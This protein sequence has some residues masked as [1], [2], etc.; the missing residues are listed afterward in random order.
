MNRYLHEIEHAASETLRLIWFEH[1]QMEEL[2]ARIASA[3]AEV[4]DAAQRLAWLRLNPDMDDDNLSTAV[5]W[6]T[7]FGPEKERFYA[8]KSRPD[9]ESLIALRA[10]STASQSGSML[11]YAKQGISLVH[12]GPSACPAGRAIHS[13][14][15]KRGRN[16]FLLENTTLTGSQSRHDPH[17]KI[18]P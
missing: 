12:N 15:L 9:L 2:Q 8:E 17:A 11:Q 7:Y 18:I 6:D 1:Q 16:C 3:T 13:Q 5:Y 4:Q 10:F 14:T